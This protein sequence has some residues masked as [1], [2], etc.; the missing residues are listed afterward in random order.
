MNA[1]APGSVAS[2]GSWI[3]IQSPSL[4][5]FSV[6]WALF[7]GVGLWLAFQQGFLAWEGSFLSARSLLAA[8]GDPAGISNIGLVYPP[9]AYYLALPFARLGLPHPSIWLSG[10]VGALFL[11]WWGN[12]FKHQVGG[13]YW[14]YRAVALLVPLGILLCPGFWH[15]STLGNSLV[16]YHVLL[17]F[18]VYWL[19][20]FLMDM[21]TLQRARADGRMSAWVNSDLYEHDRLPYL[22][23]T[24][25]ILG[26][27]GFAKFDLL[28]A[29]PW[30]I[31]LS[32]L[33]FPREER[34]DWNKQVTLGL[35][36]FL[37][38]LAC[39]AMWG[40]LCWVFRDDFFYFLNHPSSYYRQV[41]QASFLRPDILYYKGE[42]IRILLYFLK[43]ILITSPMLLYLQIRCRCWPLVG[44]TLVPIWVEGV[45]MYQGVSLLDR[46]FFGGMAMMAAVLLLLSMR[47][48]VIQGREGLVC[49]VLM[50]ASMAPHWWYFSQSPLREERIWMEWASTRKLQ[51]RNPQERLL[52]DLLRRNPEASQILMDESSGY[53]IVDLTNAPR[54]FILPYQEK[55]QSALE[56]PGRHA[57]YVLFKSKKLSPMTSDLVAERWEVLPPEQRSMFMTE[58]VVAPWVL[59]RREDQPTLLQDEDLHLIT[60][61]TEENL[62][63]GY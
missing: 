42:P 48:R 55:F 40:Y 1:A 27:C 35:L 46:E 56:N 29:L 4:I 38:L 13:Q 23:G 36:L 2:W 6:F 59:L 24:G 51:E 37:P 39:Q 21:T 49:A 12:R 10:A 28:W 47:S 52:A 33:F 30:L 58:A 9:L 14:S 61:Q 3:S 32:W 53:C 18:A 44:L 62:T 34:K 57:R 50:V 63:L 26:L 41:D 25:L 8:R 16:L 7:T 20:R 11:V 22:W 5:R 15:G 54:K 60:G 19:G 45:E 17:T 43:G 31:P